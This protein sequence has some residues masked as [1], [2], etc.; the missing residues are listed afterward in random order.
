[1]PNVSVKLTFTQT[2]ISF[3]GAQFQIN[4]EENVGLIGVSFPAVESAAQDK[5]HGWIRRIT[6]FTSII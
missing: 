5:G 6:R 1:M 2:E 4:P 3:N